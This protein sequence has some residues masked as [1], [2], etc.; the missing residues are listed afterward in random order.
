MNDLSNDYTS[1]TTRRVLCLLS[2][3]GLVF[4]CLKKIVIGGRWMVNAPRKL[5]RSDSEEG[6]VSLALVFL[7]IF[8][9]TDQPVSLFQF[10]LNFHVIC[11]LE[12]GLPCLHVSSPHLHSSICPLQVVCAVVL[13]WSNHSMPIQFRQLQ[14][15][16]LGNPHIPASKPQLKFDTRKLLER[17]EHLAIPKLD[18]PVLLR[19]EIVVI[20]KIFSKSLRLCWLY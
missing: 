10:F 2:Y 14:P 13:W 8:R 20:C 4:E 15:N 11:R 18:H 16:S 1:L 3:Y 5:T 19:C 17:F 9:P 12:C 7:V 6:P